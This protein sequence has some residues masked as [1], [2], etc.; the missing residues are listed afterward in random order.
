MLACV[1]ESPAAMRAGLPR[2][3]GAAPLPAPSGLRP[4]PG[5]DKE[6]G[7][8]GA[9]Q[10]LCA[11]PSRPR[12]HT[13]EGVVDLAS[14]SDEEGSGGRGG[15]T[16]GRARQG[17]APGSKPHHRAPTPFRPRQQRA[18]SPGP[19]LNARPAAAKPP[20]LASPAPSA[21]ARQEQRPPPSAPRQPLDAQQGAAT[22]PHY[23]Q[24]DSQFAVLLSDP[25]T[26]QPA[27]HQRLQAAAG[28]PASPRAPPSQARRPAQHAQQ[29]QAVAVVSPRAAADLQEESGD[30]H[31]SP[32]AQAA[33]SWQ[34]QQQQSASP[35]VDGHPHLEKTA[36]EPGRAWPPQTSTCKPLQQQRA[37]DGAAG[38]A[39]PRPLAPAALAGP[40]LLFPQLWRQQQQQRQHTQAAGSS[41]H[42]LQLH[43]PHLAPASGAGSTQQQQQ[44]HGGQEGRKTRALGSSRALRAQQ[45]AC[46]VRKGCNREQH[47]DAGT[48]V[49]GGVAWPW[50]RAPRPAAT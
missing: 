6:D 50:V 29:Q 36:D 48:A 22:T 8:H 40:R 15:G 7:G 23:S 18:L 16:A 46:E 4:P 43:R 12:Q 3:P 17:P 34:Q 41:W 11:T 42:S 25:E 28:T 47:A 24:P 21:S 31:P 30:S 2:S 33:N 45:L 26:T 5:G 20:S 9:C 19:S 13:A 32:S 37:A 10:R 39:A 49:G 14:S 38:T 44:Q 35:D 27:L 1:R